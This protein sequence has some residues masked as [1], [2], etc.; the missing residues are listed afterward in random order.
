MNASISIPG[1][2]SK[3]LSPGCSILPNSLKASGVCEASISS[4][5]LSSK[6]QSE[7]YCLCSL[8]S[9]ESNAKQKPSNDE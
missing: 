1:S 4:C 2:S 3:R 5:S 8:S 6:A 7:F 9:A